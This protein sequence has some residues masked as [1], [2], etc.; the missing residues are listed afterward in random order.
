MPL[1]FDPSTSDVLLLDVEEGKRATS[2]FRRI[3]VDRVSSIPEKADVEFRVKTPRTHSLWSTAIDGVQDSSRTKSGIQPTPG[4]KHL[5]IAT[6]SIQ[7]RVN[8]SR[9][10]RKRSDYQASARLLSNRHSRR[11]DDRA[12]RRSLLPLCPFVRI[13]CTRRNKRTR[14]AIERHAR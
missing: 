14:E 13:V 6:L 10:W 2:A 12:R 3:E 1:R 8:G 9:R 11:D 5:A 4:T 7:Q